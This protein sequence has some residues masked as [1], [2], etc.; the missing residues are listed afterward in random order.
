MIVVGVK[1]VIVVVVVVRCAVVVSA[2]K[3]GNSTL[4]D[5]RPKG[6]S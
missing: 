3:D 2:L 4:K 1:I 6:R 5:L